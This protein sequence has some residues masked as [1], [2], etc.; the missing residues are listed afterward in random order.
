M[1]PNMRDIIDLVTGKNGGPPY[2]PEEQEAI[3]HYKAGGG[4]AEGIEELIRDMRAGRDPMDRFKE[5]VADYGTTERNK[6]IRSEIGARE[7]LKQISGD[8]RY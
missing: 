2:S 6:Q 3:A 7:F 4:P 8:G 5:P 1:M